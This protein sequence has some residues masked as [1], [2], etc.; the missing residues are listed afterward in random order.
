MTETVGEFYD[1]F[2]KENQEMKASQYV[3]KNLTKNFSLADVKD[4]T[5]FSD[6]LSTEFAHE[7]AFAR[8]MKRLV[9]NIQLFCEWMYHE[10][11]KLFTS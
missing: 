10:K 1:S 6:S 5:E 3:I 8:L 4:L 7:S 9:A 2:V 11:N